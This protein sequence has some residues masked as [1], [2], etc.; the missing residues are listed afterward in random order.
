MPYIGVSLSD[1]LFI[2]ENPNIVD[3]LVSMSK[4]MLV[5][6]VIIELQT[7]Q[8]EPFNLKRVPAIADAL[9]GLVCVSVCVCVRVCAHSFVAMDWF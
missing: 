3:G 6:K 4:H 5:A 9:A 2:D 8:H 7:F 1:L